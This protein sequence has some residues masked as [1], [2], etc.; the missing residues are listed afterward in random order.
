MGNGGVEEGGGGGEMSSHPHRCCR[1]Y[2]HAVASGRGKG[3]ER[4]LCL[5]GRGSRWMGTGRERAR[6]HGGA[7]MLAKVGCRVVG[8]VHIS[9]GTHEHRWLGS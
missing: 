1:Q 3:G 9:T 7:A 4:E 6:G 5:G 8:S 2:M